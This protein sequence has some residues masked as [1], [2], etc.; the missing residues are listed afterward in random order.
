MNAKKIFF[1]GVC[2][3]AAC[4]TQ[5]QEESQSQMPK[6]FSYQAVVRDYAGKVVADKEVGVKIEILKG[7]AESGEVVYSETLTPTSTK[8]GTVNLMIGNYNPTQ[9]AAIDWGGNFHFLRISLSL[10]GG[11]YK[12]VSTTQMLPVP[13]ALYAEKAGS[14]VNGGS[15]GN[16]EPDTPADGS[17]KYGRDFII[18][19]TD[20]NTYEGDLFAA[21]GTGIVEDIEDNGI[22]HGTTFEFNILYLKGIDL[23]LSAKIG[24]F[25]Q[26]YSGH[27]KSESTVLGR[28]FQFIIQPTEEQ[29]QTGQLQTTLSIFNEQGEKIISF[30]ITINYVTRE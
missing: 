1:A 12:V 29:T 17:L 14:V 8:T 3:L 25:E 28:Y 15:G 26:E 18:A 5:A 24:D 13:Y 11:E 10:D 30:P 19:P 21:F 23:K 27:H 7:S 16:T 4:F 2:L 6:A 9:F 20:W 22:G